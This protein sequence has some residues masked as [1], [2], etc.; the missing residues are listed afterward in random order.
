[1]SNF[2][3]VVGCA[4]ETHQHL[5]NVYIFSALDGVPASIEMLPH[6]MKAVEESGGGLDV[7]L[8]SGIRTGMDVFRALAL[9]QYIWE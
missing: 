8:D 3:P 6:I 4:S 5:R 1:M 9:G 2:Q 7:Y